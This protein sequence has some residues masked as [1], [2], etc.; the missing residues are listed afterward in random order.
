MEK[1]FSHIKFFFKKSLELSSKKE[2][3][4]WSKMQEAGDGDL[5]NIIAVGNTLELFNFTRELQK[6]TLHN[7]LQLLETN[8]VKIVKMTES[9]RFEEIIKELIKHRKKIINNVNYKTE[10][11]PS[12]IEFSQ[13]LDEFEFEK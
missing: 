9:L 1:E 8:P 6:K 10:V 3:E 12:K 2:H 13:E 11:I 4:I 7:I 5:V